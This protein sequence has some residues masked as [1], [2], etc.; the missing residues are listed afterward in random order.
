MHGWCLKLPL[1]G[2]PR[3]EDHRCSV[4]MAPPCFVVRWHHSKRWIG[5]VYFGRRLCSPI[6]VALC[7]TLVRGCFAVAVCQLRA[8]VFLDWHVLN[9]S[10]W[11]P[12]IHIIIFYTDTYGYLILFNTGIC[13]IMI[14]ILL[15]LATWNENLSTSTTSTF[16]LNYLVPG[17]L[18][19]LNPVGSWGLELTGILWSKVI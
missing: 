2:S 14:Y 10:I 13:F 5:G 12:T 15:V 19:C 8:L 16:L 7:S 9:K 18:P 4:Q 3:N 1:S 17:R 6:T 11:F